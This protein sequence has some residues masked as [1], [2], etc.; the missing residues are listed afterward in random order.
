M[1]LLPMWKKL[2]SIAPSLPYDC[3]IM[4]DFAVPLGLA[5]RIGMPTLVMDG[6][7]T[8]AG[9][10]DAARAAAAAIPGAR[11]QTLPRQTH[12]VAATAMG[13]VLRDFFQQ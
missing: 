11:H 10:G 3:R 4:G 7:K 1:R 5:Q 8:W 6:S 2:Q 9:L 12:N 13:P